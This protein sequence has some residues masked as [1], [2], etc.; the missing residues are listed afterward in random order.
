MQIDLPSKVKVFL[1]KAAQ[2][3]L[4]TFKVLHQHRI[5]VAAI[6]SRCNQEEETIWQ[7]LRSC[8]SAATVWENV[9]FEWNST[10][11]FEPHYTNW[12]KEKLLRFNKSQLQFLG[13]TLWMIWKDRNAEIHGEKRKPASVIVSGIRQYIDDYNKAQLLELRGCQQTQA[14]WLHPPL[15]AY[16]VNFDGAFKAS[17]KTGGIKVV[18]RDVDGNLMGS[19]QI[20]YKE[21]N[22]KLK[23]EKFKNFQK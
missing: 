9:H 1:W 8:Q 7:A 3:I 16:K 21:E 19:I 12:L 23:I 22:L 15:N 6:C 18:I 14:K 20:I 2:G 4:P 5:P 11:V 10:N 17:T 13:A